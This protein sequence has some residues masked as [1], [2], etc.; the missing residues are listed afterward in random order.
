VTVIAP[1]NSPNNKQIAVG[2]VIHPGVPSGFPSAPI[3]TPTNTPTATPTDTGGENPPTF[4]PTATP[5]ETGGG[6][7]PTP[8]PTFTPTATTPPTVEAPVLDTFMVEINLDATEDVV[9]GR[10]VS[11][12]SDTVI[13]MPFYRIPME[14]NPERSQAAYPEFQLEEGELGNAATIAST[15]TCFLVDTTG[16]FTFIRYCSTQPSNTLASTLAARL[17]FPSF[18]LQTATT[19][20]LSIADSYAAQ[21]IA[22]INMA[23]AGS[24]RIG[25]GPT[26]LA[27][28]QT[29]STIE[30]N[31]RITDCATAEATSTNLAVVEAACSSDT[32][33]APVTLDYWLAK[34]NALQARVPF[35][36]VD[37]MDVGFVKILKPIQ[38]T[39]GNPAVVTVIQPGDYIWGVWFDGLGHIYA[40]TLTGRTSADAATPNTLVNNLQVPSIPPMFIDNG[41]TTTIQPQAQISGICFGKWICFKEGKHRKKKP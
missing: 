9:P 33:Y 4:T 34:Y 16:N 19:S 14:V 13:D 12:T 3:I 27:Y 8:T 26:N 11:T 6:E 38:F 5:T 15:S 40:A 23:I 22:L 41:A 2:I 30:D 31:Q 20:S 35:T 10:L 24:N 37:N 7:P 32:L 36:G 28:D 39:S 17:E 21:D 1:A 29:V 25:Y 18:A